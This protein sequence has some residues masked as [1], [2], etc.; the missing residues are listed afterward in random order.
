MSKI[1]GFVQVLT[2]D[3]DPTGQ[4]KYG[5]TNVVYSTNFAISGAFKND[6][7]LA[8]IGNAA[9]NSPGALVPVLA[10]S[11]IDII[12]E[13]VKAGTEYVNPF[14]TR[15]NPVST[16]FEHDTI[17]NHIVGIKLGKVGEKMLDRI[18]DKYAEAF[19]I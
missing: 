18:L 11:T 9:A 6:E 7:N 8:F 19:V 10:G 12:Q 1:P 2:E 17:I 13:S 4:Y 5:L 15:D 3:G 14:T 16:V